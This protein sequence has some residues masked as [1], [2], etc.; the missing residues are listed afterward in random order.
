MRRL[1]L[2]LTI[3]TIFITHASAQTH[4]KPKIYIGGKAGV[5]MSKMSFSPSV[6]QSWLTGA[7]AG[8]QFRYTEEKHFGLIAELNIEQRGWQENY[9]DDAPELSYKQTLTYIQ[10]PLMTHIY[11]G[12]RKFKGFV[13]L[14]PEFG[15]MISNS[16][17]SNFDYANAST[18]PDFP[19]NRMTEQ[20]SMEIDNKFD[21]GIAAGLGM[22]YF[23]N[24]RNSINLEAR[25]YYGLGNIFPASKKD[26]F[27]ASRGMS[28]QV[29]LGYLFRLK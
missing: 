13:N 21:Y 26:V 7:M 1:G 11:F 8:V 18:L 20:L 24:R 19:D 2:L 22:E 3:I 16:I 12:S 17:S 6:E 4:Y 29:T 9:K 15:Y 27:D 14:G 10:V 5:A 23:L 25:F 28:L